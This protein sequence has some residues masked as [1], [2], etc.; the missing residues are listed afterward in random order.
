MA[1]IG[2]DAKRW[3]TGW[4]QP[5]RILAAAS[6]IVPLLLFAIL[7]WRE[8]QAETAQAQRE[9]ARLTDIFHQHALH[10]LQTQQL[11]AERVEDHIR[12]MS[13]DEIAASSE[14][15]DYLKEI[16]GEY[17]QVQAIWLADGSGR[18]RNASQDLPQKPVSVA[19]RDYFIALRDR[20]V[21]TFIGNA[22][23]ARV[24]KGLNFNMARR[25]HGAG[26]SFDGIVIVTVFSNYFID[27]W[28]SV[29]PATDTAVI[30]F[31]RDGAILAR[32]PGFVGEIRTLPPNSPVLVAAQTTESGSVLGISSMTGV[33]RFYAFRRVAPYDVFLSTGIAVQAVLAPWRQFLISYGSL[34]GLA[35]AALFT[36]SL[37]GLREAR[38]EQI[39]THR[40]QE[41]TEGLRQEVQRRAA[42]EEDIRKLNEALSH[43]AAEL[44]DANKELESFSYSVSHDLRAPLRAI[45]GFSKILL[46]EYAGTLDAEGQRLL[47][48]V[49][50]AANKM[51]RLIDD[52]LD[53]A[54]AGRVELN[55]A[56]INMTALA[57]AALREIEVAYGERRLR[58]EIKDMPGALGDGAMLQRV[59]A[60]L[61]DNAA[62]FTAPKPDGAI[63][64]GGQVEAGESVYYVKDN[65]VGFDMRHVEKLFGVFQRLHGPTEFPGTGI[66][67]AIVKRI[68]NRHGGR[69]WAQGRSGE[70]ATFFFA[71]PRPAG[72][73]QSLPQEQPSP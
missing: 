38:R 47:N 71:L 17:P 35:A 8:R 14:L 46:E 36:L 1:S 34:S 6:L 11:A 19:D 13:W 52:I 31:R 50:E 4:L 72:A 3:P 28:N 51:G 67:L 41:A 9:V 73:P 18:L 32:A 20:D 24:M 27:F 63:E 57:Q 16:V 21:G 25:R 59:W 5:F 68:V 48:V 64:V 26:G 22:V 61:L 69:V 60:N 49:S 45:N 2:F 55:R 39:V 15:H 30:L 33:E 43:R 58:V 12:G 53:F 42:A 10:V 29:A 23:E 65:G 44:E 70:G 62:K 66:G 37:M 56:Q 7:A 54:R 40:W